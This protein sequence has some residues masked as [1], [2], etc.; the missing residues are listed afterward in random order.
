M[1]VND[2]EKKEVSA[3]PQRGEEPR[4]VKPIP[5]RLAC[6]AA[7]NMLFRGMGYPT[8]TQVITEEDMDRSEKLVTIPTGVATWARGQEVC[9]ILAEPF[10]E[11]ASS[12]TVTPCFDPETGV[13]HA[14]AVVTFPDT[15]TN[16]YVAS[17][18]DADETVECAAYNLMQTFDPTGC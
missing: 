14:I 1:I 7:L 9:P 16:L 18:P 17:W 13:P 8:Y 5:A 12:L 3:A 2:I 15:G 10:R 11:E 4:V 6:E